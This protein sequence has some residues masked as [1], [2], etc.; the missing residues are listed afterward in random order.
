MPDLITIRRGATRTVILTRRYA[1]KVPALRGSGRSWLWALTAGMQAN[2]SEREWSDLD[3]VCP[4][5]WSFA[6]IVNVYPR[7]RTVAHV[8]PDAYPPLT[9]AGAP[10]RVDP[11]P[12]NV[13]VLDGRLVWLDYDQYHGPCQTCVWRQ[14]QHELT[15]QAADN[16]QEAIPPLI[17]EPVR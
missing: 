14:Q 9:I 7:A 10:L 16:R 2:M 6:G 4:V 15:R 3:S 5:T 8:D 17:H 13:G 12:Q 1:I 11:K